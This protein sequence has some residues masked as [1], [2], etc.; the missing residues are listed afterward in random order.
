VEQAKVVAH[1]LNGQLIKGYTTD[2]FPK[3]SSFH[4]TKTPAEL[5]VEVSLNDLKALFFVRDFDGNPE[6]N[7]TLEFKEGH[8]YQG[9]KAE[10]TFND[11]EKMAG[12]IMSYDRERSGFFLI[13][14]DEDEGN[15]I[16]IFVISAAVKEMTFL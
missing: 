14:V 9:R 8:L 13:P 7:R 6:Y 10:I 1:L 3:R 11:G 16:R 4:V 5:G 15:N 2:F 12:T